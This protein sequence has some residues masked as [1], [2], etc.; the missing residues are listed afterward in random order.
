MASDF[1]GDQRCVTREN[2]LDVRYV[3]LDLV[4]VQDGDTDSSSES[5]Q[6]WAYLNDSRFDE[7]GMAPPSFAAKVP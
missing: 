5:V 6:L 7:V 4:E 2:G 1:K 3:R